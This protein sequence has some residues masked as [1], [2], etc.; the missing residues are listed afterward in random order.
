MI[1]RDDPSSLEPLMMT[2]S[3]RQTIPSRRALVLGFGA[4]LLAAGA[5]L[6]ED[7]PVGGPD[8][9][10]P[11]PRRP[12]PRPHKPKPKAP[13]PA[14]KEAVEPPPPVEAQPG[15][16]PE[17]ALARLMEGNARYAAGYSAHPDMDMIRRSDV[18]REQ[19][20]FASIVACS[21]SRVSPEL[22]FDQGLGDL[23]VAR[24]AGNVIDDAV[25]A[26][27]EYSV[28]HLGSTLI[29]VVGHERCGA[30]KATMDA[31]DGHP[32]DEDQGTLIGVLAN[33]IA[34]AVRAV[35]PGTPDRL[36][37]A[38][39]LNAAYAAADVF[40]RS[41]PLRARVLAGKLKIV[42]ARYDLDDGKVTPALG[43]G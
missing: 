38:V 23:F 1:P 32:N 42:A 30:V 6:A 4:A 34:P 2:R 41:A 8:P 18:A 33:L 43:K 26:S 37:A 14:P 7:P 21:D 22:I 31:L 3:L 10:A 13:P 25:L 17:L 9:D 28:I 24:V 35:P 16:D 5:A 27:L 20:P 39:S 15:M 12:K 29:M 19:R 36:D 40:S 11:H